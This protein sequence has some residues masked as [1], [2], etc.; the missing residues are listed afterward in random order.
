MKFWVLLKISL[1]F[2]ADV[3]K[4]ADRKNSVGISKFGNELSA[5]SRSCLSRTVSRQF[6]SFEAPD[7]VLTGGTNSMA[8]IE[9]VQMKVLVILSLFCLAVWA[10]KPICD[11]ETCTCI[12]SNVT[13]NC[14]SKVKSTWISM[15][16][17][18]HYFVLSRMTLVHL[19]PLTEY[20]ILI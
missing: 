1:R 9:I 13:C 18:V 11:L 14:K 7:S 16:Q 2:V 6:K 12:A 15:K 4:A 8:S 10:Q 5:A 3:D 19:G 20:L 17:I